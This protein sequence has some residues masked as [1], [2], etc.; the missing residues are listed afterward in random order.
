MRLI[1]SVRFPVQT[2]ESETR[3]FGRNLLMLVYGFDSIAPLLGQDGYLFK[4][5]VNDTGIVLFPH[6]TEHQD[7]TR[8][9]IQYVEE[10][11]GN[12]L[13]AVVM[14]GRIE[15]RFHRQ[16]SDERVK[17]LVEKMLL[18]PELKFART[19]LVTYQARPLS[20]DLDNRTGD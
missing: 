11:A 3:T 7:E 6:T 8:P 15:L 17:R 10:S 14:P 18:L 16:F 13:A 12:A 5:L 4:M 9:G 20:L 19:F 1:R 2:I